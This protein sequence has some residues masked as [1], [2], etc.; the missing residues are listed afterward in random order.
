MLFDDLPL[1]GAQPSLRSGLLKVLLIFLATRLIVWT[2]S[3]AGAFIN[4][5]IWNGLEPP[6]ERHQET[7]REELLDGRK[8]SELDRSWH[9]KLEQFAPLMNF[10]GKHYWSIISGGYKYDPTVTRADPPHKREQNIAF[11]PLYPLACRFVGQWLDPRAA[12]ILV[13]NVAALAAAV[14][15]Y[16]W[17]RRR[18]G[19]AA[20]IFG[21]AALLCLPPACY[22][23]YAYAESLL[24]LLIIATCMLLERRQW[25]PAAVL[26]GVA[27]ASR[28]TALGLAGVFAIAYAVGNRHLPLR[29]LALRSIPLL[30]VA[31]GGIAAY[32]IYL[33][34]LTGSWTSY[35]D[36]FRVGWVPDSQR[37]EWYQ[38]LT[39]ARMWDQFKHFGRAIRGFPI[40][41][42]ELINPF[43]WNIAICLFIVFLS[44]WFWRRVPESFRPLL[45][46][47]PFIFLQSYLASGGATF[48]VQ[49]MSR[50]MAV[51]APA[52]VVLGAW[53][54]NHW[55]PAA[56]HVLLTFMLL[57]QGAWAFRFGLDEWSS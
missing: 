15:F 39:G 30:L 54:A 2:G 18:A 17:A 43:A 34:V 27:T 21:V 46:L 35:F 52:F 31:V 6:F 47:G 23:T 41:L 45:L 20:A 33:R 24:L 37:A 12:M 44:L 53:G 40:G 16:L 22:Y 26:C 49:P 13:A 5:R 10:D 14:L 36:N 11:F 4:F 57:I 19:D 38:Y 48:G 1:V 55:R 25:L 42:I 56:R 9:E 28:P 32:A 3:Y 8:D 51:A 7:M 50:Y 29:R